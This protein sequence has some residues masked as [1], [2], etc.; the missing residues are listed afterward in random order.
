VTVRVTDGSLADTK[1][2]NIVV[3]GAP[4]VTSITRTG[5]SVLVIWSSYPG[6]TYRVQ[7]RPDL[8]AGSSWASIGTAVT[9]TGYT[10][11]LTVSI[12]GNNLRFFRVVL[13]D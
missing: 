12:A 4:Q 7:A 9:A 10:S 8:S 11:S 6:K 5:N 1:S 2:F 13:T 3:V